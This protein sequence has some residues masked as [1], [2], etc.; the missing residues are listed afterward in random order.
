MT[1]VSKRTLFRLTVRVTRDLP[2]PP[3]RVWAL[4]TDASAHVAWNSTITRLDGAIALG[5]RL[6]LE[7]PAAP[8]R[9]FRPTVVAFEPPHRMVWQD[10]VAPVFRGTRTFTLDPLPDGHTR[11]TMEEVFTGAMLPLIAP[12]LPDF[13][14]VFDRYADDLAGACGG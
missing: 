9:V 2:A 3:A 1:A 12:S 8:G 7:V 4:L 6:A 5:Q 11:F 10:G 13:A 14:P